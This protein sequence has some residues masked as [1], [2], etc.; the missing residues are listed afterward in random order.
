MVLHQRTLTTRV[1]V[2]SV[3]TG[4]CSYG[5]LASVRGMTDF[6]DADLRSAR[7]E[8]VDLSGARLRNVDLTGTRFRGVYLS[9]VV[10]RGA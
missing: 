4:S 10:M 2:L 9:G 6:V 1:T 3:R 7:F 8:R 5:T